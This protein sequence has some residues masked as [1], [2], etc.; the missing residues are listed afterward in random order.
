M[1][2]QH[3]FLLTFLVVQDSEKHFTIF[4]SFQSFTIL[5]GFASRS[6][7]TLAADLSISLVKFN[8]LFQLKLLHMM[9]I[10]NKSVRRTL[11]WYVILQAYFYAHVMD[12]IFASISGWSQRPAIGV[13]KLEPVISNQS[14]TKSYIAVPRQVS[15]ATLPLSQSNHREKSQRKAKQKKTKKTKTVF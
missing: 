7:Q 10:I 5:Y 14:P 4:L 13:T 2:N 8:Y 12:F 11:I 15:E 6:R 3:T 9:D 1:K